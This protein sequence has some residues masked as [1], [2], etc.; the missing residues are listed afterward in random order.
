[1]NS[2]TRFSNHQLIES[3]K[4]LVSKEQK[5]SHEIVLHLAEVDR[6]KLFADLGFSSLFDYCTRGLGYSNAS[7]QRRICA[8]RAVKA[9][10]EVYDCLAEGKVSF[11][12]L[13]VASTAIAKAGG[14]ELLTEL[15][16]V[17]CEEAQRIVS[18]RFPEARKRFSDK[19]VAVVEK[20]GT[21]APSLFNPE[22]T[23]N[24]FRAEVITKPVEESKFRITI[25]V[26][27]EFARKLS[28]VKG[29]SGSGFEESGA[30]LERLLDEYIE[31]NSPETRIKRREERQ[32]R[33]DN[34]AAAQ[35]AAQSESETVDVCEELKSERYGSN[36]F[37][38]GNRA[39]CK[40]NL[41]DRSEPRDRNEPSDGKMRTDRN[42]ANSRNTLGNKT[43]P[44]TGATERRFPSAAL[45][46]QVLKRDGFQC[47]FVSSDGIR[48]SC[49]AGLQVD[50]IRPWAAGGRTAASNLRALCR[51]HNLMFARRVFGTEKLNRVIETRSKRENPVASQQRFVPPPTQ[52]RF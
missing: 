51:A 15:C 3:L 41:F 33:K 34:V 40:D 42:E 36:E 6:R 32:S 29:L 46:D 1:M 5:C 22:G 38:S 50:H 35:T 49:T 43:L 9:V 52:H 13:D 30:V 44:K 20:K 21:P 16:G 7:A 26:G 25:T 24:Y 23:T 10:P 27:S 37:D 11:K 28:R 47:S 18:T 12:V 8:A 39:E 48:C 19:I 45:R 17:G 31:R 4:A 14:K 2:L